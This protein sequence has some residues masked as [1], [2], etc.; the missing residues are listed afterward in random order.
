M[1]R[2]FAALLLLAVLASPAFAAG[3]PHKQAHA[4]PDYRYH[5]PKYR[6]KAAKY[7]N[8]LPPARKTQQ[9]RSK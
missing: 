4:K 3:K 6:Y 7:Q 2:L 1:K 8:H 5:T 9:H